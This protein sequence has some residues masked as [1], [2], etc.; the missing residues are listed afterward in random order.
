MTP[1]RVVVIPGLG[2]RRYLL[3]TMDAVRE[4]GITVELLPALGQPRV[5]CDLSGYADQMI[6]ALDRG[7][8]DVIVGLSIGSQAAAVYASRHHPTAPLVLVGPTVDPRSRNLGALLGRWL[9]AGRR[10]PHG[11]LS[12]QLADW[13]DA[14]PQRL[15]AVLRSAVAVRLEDLQWSNQEDTVIVHADQDEV[16]S[17]AYAA[18]LSSRW[19]CRLV[20]VPQAAHSWPYADPDRFVRLLRTIHH[21]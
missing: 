21:G 18:D 2:V 13:W 20:S 12:P 5:A 15:L 4:R 19:R 9:I 11:L 1:L 7:T 10:E 17:H 6:R 3:P 14:G 16:T 8:P